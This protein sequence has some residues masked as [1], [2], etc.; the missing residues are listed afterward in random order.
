MSRFP[1][2]RFPQKQRGF[3]LLITITLLAFLVL[4]LVSLASLTRV[5][6]QVAGNSQQLSQARQNALAALNIALGQ[7]QRFA[8]PDQRAT[9][10]ADLYAATNTVPASSSGLAAPV[11]GT[12]RWT[13]VWG[14]RNTAVQG[15]FTQTPTPVLLNWLVS[16]NE[17]L[18]VD[19]NAATGLMNT[20]T[21][22]TPAYKPIFDPGLTI[23]SIATSPLT[24]NGQPAV[25]LVGPKTAGQSP[26]VAADLTNYI[27]APLVPITVD[28]STIPGLGTSGTVDIGRYAFWVGDEGVKAPYTLIDR[29]APSSGGPVDPVATPVDASARY[30]LAAAQR[31]AL[32]LL[33]GFSAYPANST[34]LGQVVLPKQVGLADTMST[35]SVLAARYHD[36]TTSS[37]GVLADSLQGGLRRDLT[38]AFE[39]GTSPDSSNPNTQ[40]SPAQSNILPAG[41]SPKYGP[42]WE[43][44][45]AHYALA[46]KIGSI[47]SPALDLSDPIVHKAGVA[48]VIVQ[49]R[50]FWKLYIDGSG[51]PF[52]RTHVVVVVGNPY[53]VRLQAPTGI[54]LT[55][56]PGTSVGG[57][58]AG[59]IPVVGANSAA[60]FSVMV[61][62]TRPGTVTAPAFPADSVR[63]N[64]YALFK[65]P[66]TSDPSALSGTVFRIVNVDLAPGEAKAFAVSNTPGGPSVFNLQE[67]GAGGF[68]TNYAQVALPAP[69]SGPGTPFSAGTPVG[70]TIWTWL[71]NTF[72]RTQLRLAGT[73]DV[74]QEIV[75]GVTVGN[76]QA[77]PGQNG[78]VA[79]PY[80]LPVEINIGGM[81][82]DLTLPGADTPGGTYQNG[83]GNFRTYA[84]YNLRARSHMM[85]GSS[86]WDYLKSFYPVPPYS[87]YPY[88]VASGGSTV[89]NFSG[90]NSFTSN[91]AAQWG[92]DLFGAQTKALLFDV[93]RRS[94][95]D[96]PP[97][98]SIGA[99]QHANATADDWFAFIGS[100]P[101][102]A[103]GNSLFTPY[104]TT[105]NSVQARANTWFGMSGN[106]TYYDIS[107]LLNTALWDRYFFSGIP[108]TGGTFAL[109][110]SGIEA[111]RLPNA[112]LRLL[113]DATTT[114]PVLRDLRQPAARMLIEGAFNVNS[115]SE[116]AWAALLA[117]ARNLTLNGDTL[118]TSAGTPVPRHLSPSLTSANA[119][120]ENTSASYAGFRKLTDTQINDL[121]RE[122]VKQVRERGPFLSLSHFINRTLAGSADAKSRKGPLQAAID[123][124]AGINTTLAAGRPVYW[125][126]AD[127]G[128]GSNVGPYA[129]NKLTQGQSAST[130]IPGWLTQADL[131]QQIGPSLTTRSDTF[132]VRA[133]GDVLDPL[134]STPVVT[135]RAWCEATVQRFP[136]YVESGSAG[137]VATIEPG[138]A[139]TTNQQFGRRFRIV[140]FRWLTPD[141][142]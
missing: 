1:D 16:G 15:S 91:I 120:Q 122:I 66:A 104:V 98:V 45:A 95:A 83:R 12:R 43:T 101:G 128:G 60:Y 5:E 76:G 36:Y 10:R 75:N 6:V 55:L 90:G 86:I 63:S 72:Y 92:H 4:L 84:D 70:A 54:D 62:N 20:A 131:L 21:A 78:S 27:V 96:D 47:T 24:L 52:L 119:Q 11:D 138:S 40:F 67:I 99:L 117:G 42:T 53:N 48:P 39:T 97:I 2:T 3:A 74:L 61:G 121:A 38:Y 85:P 30:R 109:N 37:R 111:T 59:S 77:S 126:N 94:G 105:A 46:G 50:F 112:R 56:E 135:G 32:E 57:V 29:H 129:D 31:A 79:T 41:L 7:L 127:D 133:Y 88:I 118:A 136:D 125:P 81:P 18:T 68:P 110:A 103:I 140:S 115:T 25:L 106:S 82:L 64:R 80:S 87:S 44:L 137:N 134:Q 71:T 93:P 139:T 33:P 124:T 28:K 35:S 51:N 114:L 23:S 142:I 13:G 26:V 58:P 14:H 9:G 130:G 108:P 89:P 69:I 73:T 8:G 132:T 65:G 141:D 113:E 49:T 17:N 116:P 100:Q 123:A 107:Y 102:N 19:F 34:T 22:A